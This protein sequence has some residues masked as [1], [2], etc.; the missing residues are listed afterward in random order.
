[1][2]E[3]NASAAALLPEL[4]GLSTPRAGLRAMLEQAAMLERGGYFDDAAL[5]WQ[6]GGMQAVLREERHWCET[7]ALLCQKRSAL[8]PR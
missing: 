5:Y 4:H 1:M 3:G 8:L 7:R 2:M 6:A